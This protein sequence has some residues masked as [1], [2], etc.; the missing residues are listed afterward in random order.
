[1]PAVVLRIS[2][3]SSFIV[4]SR[5]GTENKATIHSAHAYVFMLALHSYQLAPSK[6]KVMQFGKGEIVPRLFVWLLE[7]NLV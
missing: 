6:D 1:M 4:S 3:P 2:P 7:E 5:C